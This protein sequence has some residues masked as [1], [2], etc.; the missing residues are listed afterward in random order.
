MPLPQSVL[1]EATD[2]R[3]L[4]EVVSRGRVTRAELAATTGLSKPT[5]SEAVRRLTE[6]GLL[7]ATGA[8]ETGRRGRVGTFYELG[9]SAGR[10]LA[11][12]VGQS[13]VRAWS[14]DLAG[15]VLGEYEHPAGAAGDTDAVVAALRAVVSEASAGKGILRA[16]AVSMANPVDPKTHEVVA[17]PDSPFP[18]GLLSPVDVLADLVEAPVLV[19]NDVNLAALA[20]QRAGGAVGV[21]SF[22]YVYVGAGLGVGLYIG[23]RLVRGA[24]GLAG[25][26]GYLPGAGSGTLAAELADGFGRADA[27]SND[28]EAALRI[29]DNGETGALCGIVV[30]AV[31]S[32]TAVVDPELVLLGGPV[33][34]HPALLEP[35]R[36]ALSPSPTRLERG[37]LGTLAS[38]HGATYSA[39]EHARTAAVRVMSG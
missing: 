33:G 34:C 10:V 15:T 23:D 18:E 5:V 28:V 32:I 8:Q 7:E 39:L 2:R 14:T 3:L 37:T 6:S 27:P 29:L 17:L 38:L 19:D 20:E 12:E 35:V 1:R 25:E 31:A 36:E 21:S 9:P 24:H 13:G 30:R 22:A 26:I 4:D 16:V 11:I